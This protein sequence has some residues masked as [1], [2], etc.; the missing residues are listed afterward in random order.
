M[1]SQ[2]ALFQSGI[3]VFSSCNAGPTATLA[4]VAENNHDRSKMNSPDL[5]L[6]DTPLGSIAWCSSMYWDVTGLISLS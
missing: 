1:A 2:S 3:C 4:T 6:W 5:L